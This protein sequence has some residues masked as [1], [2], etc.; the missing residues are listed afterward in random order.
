MKMNAIYFYHFMEFTSHM[1][2]DNLV[3]YF[4]AEGPYLVSMFLVIYQVMDALASQRGRL[5]A[6]EEIVK[7]ATSKLVEKKKK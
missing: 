4:S 7:G 1:P 5:S 3:P 2:P 6:A